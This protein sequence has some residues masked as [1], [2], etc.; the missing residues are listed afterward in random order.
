M[1]NILVLVILF[2]SVVSFGQS[3]VRYNGLNKA[4]PVDYEIGL[5]GYANFYFAK[6]KTID[7]GAAESNDNASES[8]G[9]GLGFYSH[10]KFS[11]HVG[12]Q[13]ELNVHFRKGYSKSSRQYDLD[14][15]HV[16]YKEDLSNYSTVSIEI[17]VYLKFHWEFTPI[18]RGHWKTKSQLGVL[19][20]PRLVLNPSSK[21]ELSR[22]TI[23]RLYDET[24]QSIE[25]NITATTKYNTSAS[26]GFSLGVD[27]ELW[28]G[29]T[30]HAAYYRGLTTH[31]RKSNGF[32]ALDNRIEIGIGYRFN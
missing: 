19:F 6:Y 10:F 21:R 30:V 8:V 18:H 20:G 7:D 25:N 5:K 17:P 24:S 16:V 13:T 14:S 15:A 9:T 26:F 4:A 12:I 3:K 28:N 32:K 29:F 23:T 22:S 2:I 27:Y 31:V 11:E 1:K